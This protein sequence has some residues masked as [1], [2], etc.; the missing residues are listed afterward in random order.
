MSKQ[1]FEKNILCIGAGYVGGPTM[2]VIALKCPRYRV[3]LVDINADRIAAWQTD[4]LPIYEPGLLDVVAGARGRN[5]FFSTDVDGE[6][7]KADI[8]FVSVNTPTK[9]FGVGAGKAADLQYW[10]KTARNI[11]K[12]SESDKIIIEKSTLPVRTARAMERIL[13]ANDKGIHFEVLSNP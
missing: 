10:E 1:E 4:D 11:V 7:A 9:T 3:T 8:I 6:I 5:L 13:N 12:N 2:A